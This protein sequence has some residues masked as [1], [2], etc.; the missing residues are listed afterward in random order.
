MCVV[1][2]VRT[3]KQA[4]VDA[5]HLLLH[6]VYVGLG[7]VLGCAALGYVTIRTSADCFI[8]RRHLVQTAAIAG[9]VL[10]LLLVMARDASAF[11]LYAW[12]YGMAAGAY[13]LGLKLYALELV[14]QQLMERAWS[15]LSAVQCFPFLF[16]APVACTWLLLF[17]S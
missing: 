17:V 3:A 11:S 12:A 6:S 9:G 8:C 10:T 14:S 4:G 2:Q 15:F 16:G 5:Y 7:F 13:Y 1:K